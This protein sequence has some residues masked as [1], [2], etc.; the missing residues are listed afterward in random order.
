MIGE[1]KRL[2]DC[3]DHSL[4]ILQQCSD[5]LRNYLKNCQTEVIGN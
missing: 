5:T 3:C 1:H 2:V 4:A